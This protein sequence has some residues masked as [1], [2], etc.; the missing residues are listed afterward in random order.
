MTEDQ[1]RQLLS[2]YQQYQAEAD[3]LVRQLSLAQMTEQGLGRAVTAVEALSSAQVDQEILVPI[4]SGSYAYAK[5]A[6][7][8]RIILNVGGGVSLDKPV[9]QALETLKKRRAEIGEGV[10]K[11]GEAVS[12]VE[13]EMA[14]IQSVI[15]QLE[16]AAAGSEGVVQ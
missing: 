13:G 4:G 6:S 15:E 2:A 12:K 16:H 11:L 7:T 3:A 14:Q 5:L 9:D 1:V 10:R 8:D